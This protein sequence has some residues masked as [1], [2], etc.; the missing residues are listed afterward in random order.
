MKFRLQALAHL[1][2]P[3]ELDVAPRLVDPRA[4]IA[5][6]VLLVALVAAVTWSFVARVPRTVTAQGVLTPAGGLLSVQAPVAGVV[7]QVAV[8]PGDSVTTGEQ[9][10]SVLDPSQRDHAVTSPF[11]GQVVAVESLV[12][13]PITVGATVVTLRSGGGTDLVAQLFVPSDNAA[14]IAPGMH[15]LMSAESAPSAAFGLLKGDV[16]TVSAQTITPDQASAL[17]GNEILV[18]KLTSSGPQRLVTV[19][20]HIDSANRS[21][22]AWT[23]GAGPPFALPPQTLLS[24]TVQIGSQ[25]PIDFVFGH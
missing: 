25:K 23:S 4:W 7:T 19:T 11:A 1:G 16:Q 17:L 8:H 21:G 12:G 20:L 2:E 6:L 9:V 24:G 22:Y 15:V 5:V 18:R 3:E 13:Q 10:A 14:S